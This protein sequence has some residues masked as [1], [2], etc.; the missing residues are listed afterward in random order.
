MIPPFVDTDFVDAHPEAVLADVRWYLDGRDGRAAFEAG[1][2]PGAL[3]V[4]LD[5]QLAATGRAA[6]EGRHPFPEPSVFAAAMGSLGIANDTLVVAYDDTGGLTAGRLAVMLR[7]LGCD[8]TVLAGGLGAWTG[9]V[10]SGPGRNPT[11]TRFTATE[12][13]ADRLAD[14][15]DAAR[16]AAAGGAVLDARSHERFRGEVSQIDKRAGHI[17]GARCAYWA[18]VLDSHAMPRPADELRDHF[19]QLGVDNGD[20]V[21]AYCGSGVSACLNI[22]AV[23]HVGLGSPRLYVASWSGW[24]ADP[25]REAATGD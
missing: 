12:W 18:D 22:L 24:S 11:P 6:T 5:H 7:M 13:P 19:R 23:E 17:P 9:P 2:L 14:A 20:D 16:I 3:W 25:N 15:D 21:V 8:A 10:E 1:H 4:D